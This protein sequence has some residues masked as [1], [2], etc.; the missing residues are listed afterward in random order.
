MKLAIASIHDLNDVRRGSGTFHYMIEELERQGHSVIRLGP[1]QFEVPICTRVIGALHRWQGRRHVVFLDP[2]VGKR[3][4]I[5]VFRRLAGL[6]YDILLTK[7]LSMAAFTPTCKPVVVYTDVM[8]TADYSEKHLPGCRLGNMSKISLA[9]CRRTFRQAL[10]RCT[11]AAFPAEWSAQAAR[12]YCRE[13]GKIKV[14]PFGANVADPGPEIARGRRWDN[15]R[16]K[17]CINLLFVGVDWVRK[18]G[19]IAVETVARVNARG[20][21]ARLHV[22]GVKPP[23]EIA[24]DQILSY[25]FLDKSKADDLRVLN[26]LYAE[27]DVFILPS[28]NE[29]YNNSILMAAAFGLPTLA[30]D[31]N[32]V[33]DAV[34]G[35]SAGLLVPLGSSGEVFAEAIRT[36]QTQP[37][38][39][40]ALAWGARRHYETKAN[41]RTSVR[42][43]I[44]CI[45]N[46]LRVPH[47]KQTL[48]S[49]VAVRPA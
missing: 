37:S 46:S 27:S 12:S 25:G 47:L 20:I 45:E 32:G 26:R 31:A 16:R 3:T 13:P 5:Q 33:R 34:A 1:F 41:W 30:Y 15:V 40:E 2:F 4:G 44:E 6:D 42:T 36:W 38:A 22:V 11:M 29:G 9:L 23:E 43:L 21:K 24:P 49:D 10:N 35:G 39:Y 17:G 8:I 14:I 28:S 48:S 7:D 19:D 18:G